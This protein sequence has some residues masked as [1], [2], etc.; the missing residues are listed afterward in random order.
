[1]SVLANMKTVRA[2]LADLISE[3][4]LR[5]V[6]NVAEE[7]ENGVPVALLPTALPCAIVVFGGS[8]D[9]RMIPNGVREWTYTIDVRVF[10]GGANPA[11]SM[12]A[13]A[14]VIDEYLGKFD[15]QVVL[16]DAGG[17][18]QART[19]AISPLSTL[20]WGEEDYAGLVFTL[21]VTEYKRVTYAGGTASP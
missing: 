6:Y 17:T 8:N 4:V 19:T 13:L 1:M 11:Q 3:D 2:R 18:V 15:G 14:A 20:T 21:A 16:G 9:I 10:T 12:A 5:R 7:G